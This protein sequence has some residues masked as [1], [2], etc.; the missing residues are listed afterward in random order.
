MKREPKTD[1]ERP[2]LDV[3]WVE[4]TAGT[5]VARER[6]PIRLLRVSGLAGPG[7]LDAMSFWLGDL[8]YTAIA[9]ATGQRLVADWATIDNEVPFDEEEAATR[10]WIAIHIPI[11]GADALDTLALKRSIQI[12]GALATMDRPDGL[13][14]EGPKVPGERHAL[15]RAR[16]AQARTT[17]SPGDPTSSCARRRSPLGASCWGSVARPAQSRYGATQTRARQCSQTPPVG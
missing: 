7:D 11:P 16:V 9:L 13:T 15:M 2:R 5:E 4:I 6:E 14:I 10:E 8:A 12:L 1:A 17:K 3:S